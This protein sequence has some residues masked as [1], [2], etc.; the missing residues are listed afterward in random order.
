MV[1]PNV[2]IEALDQTRLLALSFA[3]Y[4]IDCLI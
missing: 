3:H 2:S 4:E 1:S